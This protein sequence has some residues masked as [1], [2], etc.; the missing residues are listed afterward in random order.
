MK[1]RYERIDYQKRFDESTKFYAFLSGGYGSGKTYSLIMKMFRLMQINFGLPGGLVCPTLKMFFRDVEP[2]ID[3]LCAK[4]KIPY[5]FNRQTSC[6]YF[7]ATRSKVWIFHDEDKGRSIKGPNLAWMAL[8]EATLLSEPGFK[9][10]IARIRLRRAKLMQ[11]ILSG[12]PEGFNHIYDFFIANPRADADVI[13][14]DVRKN[15]F[16]AE[17]YVKLLE[18]SYDDVML[19]MYLEGQ[20]VNLNGMTA[21][22]KFVRQKHTND[23][24]MP[25]LNGHIW[26]HVDF[27]VAPM[28][29]TLYSWN[30]MKRELRGFDEVY[31]PNNADTELWCKTAKDKLE[32]YG[33][34]DMESVTVYPDPAGGA[35]ATRSP[36]RT[37]LDIVR[38]TFPNVKYKSKI[39]SVKDC[40]N[41]SNRFVQR[42]KFV[43][44][45]V[46]CKHTIKDFEKTSLKDGTFELEKKD[47]KQTHFVDGF[48]N[49]IE[50]EFPITISRGGWKE[51]AI[52]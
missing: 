6:Y 2:A 44:N 17:E 26:A 47:L 40:L 16:V 29:G 28:C 46:K 18:G 19:K 25:D 7:P 32:T 13:F 48:K 45:K 38:E 1:I 41:A 43:L 30:P 4:F 27:N 5:K 3:E 15:I 34:K 23:D 12:T 35:R 42:E 24:V 21:I 11:C 22:H 49:M 37:D 14:A 31:I 51:V 39:K 52:R 33:I 9:A 36:N 50:Y 10:S 8:N 20:Y